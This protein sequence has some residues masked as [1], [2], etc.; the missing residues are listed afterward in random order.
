[1]VAQNQVPAVKKPTPAYISAE[2]C[3]KCHSEQVPSKADLCRLTEYHYWDKQDR[4]RIAWTVLQ[5]K[6]AKQIGALLGGPNGKDVSKDPRC[7]ACHA[8][9]TSKI[10]PP[11]PNELVDRYKYA[12]TEGVSCVE[13]HGPSLEWV[14]Y[15]GLPTREWRTYPRDKK[16]REYGMFDLWNP[17]SRTKLCLSCHLGDVDKGRIV[18]HEMFAAGHPP[19]PG[20]EVAAYSDEQPRHWQYL[21]EKDPP[22]QKLLGFQADR[23]ERTELIAVGGLVALRSSLELFAAQA[24][25]QGKG[26]LWPEYARFDCYACHHDLRS[27]SL[28]Q[29]Q[30]REAGRTP[31][32]PRAPSWPGVLAGLSIVAANPALA[33][34]REKQLRAHM[35]SFHAA[36]DSRPFGDQAQIM[37]SVKRFSTWADKIIGELADLTNPQQKA[38]PVPPQAV[39]IIGRATAIAMLRRICDSAAQQTPDFDSARQMAWACRTIYDELTV[40]PA[41]DDPVVKELKLLDRQLALTLR[42]HASAKDPF[43]TKSE[44]KPI[45]EDEPFLQRLKAVTEYDPS[46]VKSGFATIAKHLPQR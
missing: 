24:A 14:A 16:E 8:I 29:Q 34:D 30:T 38:P 33:P 19:L 11:P 13:C 43:P 5:E 6:R 37:D 21:R 2:Y 23:L 18:T 26:S 36:L 10:A 39:P 41:E 35:Q 31:G 1:M 12:A 32:R 40:Q 46:L 44:Q 42:R 4:H 22:I 7:I 15:H 45:V 25:Q 27:P 20:I 9:D 3:K 28:T 17:V